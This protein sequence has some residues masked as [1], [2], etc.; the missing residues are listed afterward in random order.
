MRNMAGLTGSVITV[1]LMNEIRNG[2]GMEKNDNSV[3]AIKSA[4][5]YTFSSFLTKGVIFLTTPIFTRLLTKGDFGSF[6][7]FSSWM[8][9]LAIVAT[10]HLE[11]ATARAR[12]DFEDD[13]DGYISSTV[14]CGSMVSLL[15]YIC[16]LAAPR[17]FSS[18]FDIDIIYLHI[19]CLFLIFSPAFDMRQIKLRYEYKY[20]S[21]VIITILVTAG[22]TLTAVYMVH[23]CSDKLFGRIMG[24]F[25]PKIAVYIGMFIFV[26]IRGKKLLCLEYWKYAVLYS[27]PIIPH[28]LS[29]VILGSSDKIMIT[30]MVNKEAAAIYSL[31]YSCGM[32]I[33]VF[34]S[35]F[36]QAMTPWLSEKL[37]DEDYGIIKKV[38]RW[39]ILCFAVMVEGMILI[40]PELI[41][42][43][44]GEKYAGAE[45]LIAPVMTGYGFKFA[46]TSYVNIEQYE[47]KTGAVSVGTLLAAGFNFL[48][49]LICIPL[50]GFQ[51]AAYTTLAGF[52]ML[53]LIHYLICRKYGFSHIYDN[54]FTF[55]V[56]GVML[57]AGMLSQLLYLNFVLRWVMITALLVT[58]LMILHRLFIY[59]RGK[60]I[61]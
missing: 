50:F 2:I 11:S 4:F 29:N 51:A 47:K 1:P 49:N 52:I 16:V 25:V 38:N 32:I 35:S 8:S 28:L 60:R 20:I 46:Y 34:L 54:R 53:L 61:G 14:F 3:K 59:Y 10:L 9:I 5:W 30:K 19:L 41:K 13:F 26:M 12:F 39:Y 6:S 33:S 57:A 40:A 24:E 21:N 36:N 42:F 58:G 37:H 43:L 7:N 31:A 23:I 48:A 18:V 44:G 56:M 22:S 45:Y 17:F 15:F 27:V 55:C